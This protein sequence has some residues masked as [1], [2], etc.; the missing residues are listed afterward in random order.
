V[1]KNILHDCSSEHTVKKSNRT[2]YSVAQEYCSIC[3]FHF[4]PSVI[5]NKLVFFFIKIKILTQLFTDYQIVFVYTDFISQRGP[6][7]DLF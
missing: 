2:E 5:Q 1:P 6:P 4:Y 3:D 7:S